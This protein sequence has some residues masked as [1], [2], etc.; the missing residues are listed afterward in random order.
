MH[1]G[2]PN[3]SLPLL[4]GVGQVAIA[5]GRL[6]QRSQSSR[7]PQT[8]SPPPPKALL[9]LQAEVYLVSSVTPGLNWVS[10]PYFYLRGTIVC[11]LDHVNTS[12]NCPASIISCFMCLGGPAC[13]LHRSSGLGQPRSIYK[14]RVVKPLVHE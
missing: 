6:A 9:P 1:L 13:A 3:C 12:P 4:R 14:E 10:L 11:R 5:Q 8:L 2:A 7:R